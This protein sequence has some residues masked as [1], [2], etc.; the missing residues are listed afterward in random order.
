M[1]TG[2]AGEPMDNKYLMLMMIKVAQ[3]VNKK[4]QLQLLRMCSFSFT[5]FNGDGL[6]RSPPSK[7]QQKD[8]E[9]ERV[10]SLHCTH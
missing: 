10:V 1:L 4:Q 6:Q 2:S 8:E 9:D 3:R 7:N 5:L